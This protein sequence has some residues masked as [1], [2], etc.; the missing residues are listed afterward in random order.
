MQV[1]V[2][3]LSTA[4]LTASAALMT[5]ASAQ[6]IYK[7]GDSYSQ[8]PCPGG[9]V[10]NA[11]DQRTSAQKTQ[12]VLAS[13]RDAQTA[14]AMEKARLQQEKTDLAANTPTLK[15]ASHGKAGTPQK[16]QVKKKQKKKLAPKKRA[17]QKG[18]RPS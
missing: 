3:A 8:L 4:F 16:T 15:P 11:T 13:S 2:L 7:C 14:E 12:S 9:V 1:L 17:D 18:W 6:T 5:A 10:I